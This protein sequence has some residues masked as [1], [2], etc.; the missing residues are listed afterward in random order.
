MLRVIIDGPRDPRMNM[1]I[2]EAIARSRR[3]KDFDTLRLYMWLPSGVSLGRRQSF[4]ETVVLDEIIRRGYVYVRRP[5]GGAALL[6]PAFRELTYSVV[7]SSNHYLYSMD[8]ASSAAKIAEGI[9]GAINALGLEAGVRGL[10]GGGEARFCYLNPGSSDVM[11]LG[12][13]ISGSAQRREWGSLLQHGTILLEYD[14]EDFTSVIRVSDE[15]KIYATQRIAGLRD[16]IRD[17]DLE[18]LVELVIDSMRKVLG[19]EDFFV[20]GLESD[21]MRLA[22]DLFNKKYSS[23]EWNIMGVDKFSGGEASSGG[24]S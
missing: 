22:I 1:A 7:L 5:T 15:E 14:P 3:R 8:V 10:G 13:K 18:R 19:Y 4:H 16:F 24:N 2:D 9:A 21:E 20:G 6:H 11:I 23:D 17:L 12:R